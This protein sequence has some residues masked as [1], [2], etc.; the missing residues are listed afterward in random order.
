[1]GKRNDNYSDV[2][3]F[4]YKPFSLPFTKSKGQECKIAIKGLLSD[5]IFQ[6]IRKT[7]TFYEISL[8]EASRRYLPYPLDLV[9]D[10][11]ANIGNHAIFWAKILDASVVCVEPSPC[12]I[13]LLRAN[14]ELNHLSDSV[15][16]VETAAGDRQ[17][18]AALI[19]AD[20]SNIGE[21]RVVDKGSEFADY[22]TVPMRTVTDIVA[23]LEKEVTR[24]VSLIKIDVEGFEQRVITGAIP[25]IER[26]SP[27]LITELATNQ[28]LVW[29]QECLSKYGY[30][31]FIKLP[32]YTPT[33]LITV[34]PVKRSCYQDYI[35]LVWGSYK[36][37]RIHHWLQWAKK[38]KWID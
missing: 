37:G 10:V 9:I 21:T 26:D 36:R 19:Q 5:H 23:Q 1:M 18:E 34:K 17:G 13:K 24:K 2:T 11:G 25:I 29:A 32:A 38:T 3:N 20:T 30:K 14:I 6:I 35:Y 16:I 31:T 27:I 4:N 8:L 12:A 28:A 22:P 15:H 33:F 7:R